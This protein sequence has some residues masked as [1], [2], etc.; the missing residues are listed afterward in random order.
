MKIEN[1]ELARKFKLNN[2]KE[3]SRLFVDFHN[4]NTAL[5]YILILTIQYV[6]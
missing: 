1:F 6:H 5:K 3:K 4:R 2:F